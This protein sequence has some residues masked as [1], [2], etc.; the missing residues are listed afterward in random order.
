METKLSTLVGEWMQVADMMLDPEMD[1]Q[2]ILDTL[3]SIEGEISEKAD[4][5]GS[6]VRKLELEASAL[7]GKKEYVDKIA[8]DLDAEI[9]RLNNKTE[10][11]KVK[12]MDAMIAVGKDEDGI[13]TDRFIF[14]VKTAG[15]VE[16]LVTDPEKVPEEFKKKT[17]V[18][19]DDNDKIREYLKDHNVDWA[20][21]LPRKRSLQIKGV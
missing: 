16:K 4:G 8:K 7:K 2:T 21:L 19:E 13:K 3:E 1:E 20:R 11:L 17:I 6:V 5:Y 18:I 15:G 14:K 12:L 10:W 9:K